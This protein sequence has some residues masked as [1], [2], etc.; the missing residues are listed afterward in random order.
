MSRLLL[1][2]LLITLSVNSQQ[3]N[4]LQFFQTDWGRNVSW[5][6]YCEKTKA[7]GYDGIET[8]FPR[9]TEDRLALDNALK[10]HD[11]QVIYLAGADKTVDFE[12]SLERY[13]Q[14][15]LMIVPFDP[16]AINSHTGSDFFTF[17][18]NRAFIDAANTISKKNNIPI[19]HETHRS[20]FSFNLPD[21]EQYLKAIPDLKLTL[22]I[23]HW[24]V[25]HESLLGD[26]D[27]NL[28]IVIDRT[29]HIHARVG[30]QEGPQV[31]DPQ[32]PEWRNALNR[33]LDTWEKVIRK[34][35]AENDRPLTITT[36]FGPPTYMPTLPYT[37]VPVTDQWKAN[38][39]IME[40]L[41]QRMGVK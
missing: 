25:V 18:Q 19:Y 31:N 5:D 4:Q 9:K 35:W 26:Q 1:L 16:V 3:R 30:H 2:L 23:S 36:E 10:K 12:T 8:W 34:Q 28:E 22:D 24:M 39:F 32:A 14:D 29:H 41:K 40:A 15:L 11:L 37:Q 21:T 33:H 20:R 27:K 7:S 6:A 13:T 17:E 38:V